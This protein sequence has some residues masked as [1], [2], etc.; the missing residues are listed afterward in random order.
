MALLAIL[1]SLPWGAV[2]G[3]VAG[4]LQRREELERMKIEHAQRVDLLRLHQAGAVT[5]AEWQGFTAS[6]ENA[7]KE[8]GA[9]VWP[10]VKSLRYGARTLLTLFLVVA[11]VVLAFTH[12][13]AADLPPR[14]MFFAEMA[15]GW[16]FGWK[17]PSLAK[18]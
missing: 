15:L 16:H 8:D 11:A 14:V 13:G 2:I 1:G 10:W 5:A 7:S 17:A 6:Q 18:R 4:W 9:G 12:D 3:A